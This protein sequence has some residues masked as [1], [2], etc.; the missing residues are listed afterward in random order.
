MAANN[1]ILMYGAD[2]TVENNR[3]LFTI[4][5]DDV[6]HQCWYSY[7]PGDKSNVSD[8]EHNH[9]STADFD[10][11]SAWVLA[12]TPDL[13]HLRL[14]RSGDPIGNFMWVAWKVTGAPTVLNIR[15]LELNPDGTFLGWACPAITGF[16]DVTAEYVTAMAAHPT[17]HQVVYVATKAPEAFGGDGNIRVYR[18]DDFATVTKVA[19]L[20]PGSFQLV[21]RIYVEQTT[22]YVWF[23]VG[24]VQ[25]QQ[26]G[27]SGVPTADATVDGVW[28]ASDG[29]TFTL[30]GGVAGSIF[31]D[32][33]VK[34]AAPRKMWAWLSAVNPGA[35]SQGVAYSTDDGATW[36]KVTVYGPGGLVADKAV[37]QAFPPL[38]GALDMRVAYQEE[39]VSGNNV[40]LIS[41]GDGG[42]TWD[43]HGQNPDFAA[44]A[45]DGGSM[46]TDPLIV[47]RLATGQNALAGESTRTTTG[48]AAGFASFDPFLA[49]VTNGEG[50][51]QHTLHWTM[52]WIA[53]ATNAT[54]SELMI[55]VDSG[56]TWANLRA[57][58]GF[59]ST[60][61]F[62]GVAFVQNLSKL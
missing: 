53:A 47:N 36:T 59:T 41:S 12:Q 45:T 43:S 23:A 10:G 35:T 34:E 54:T 15:N 55:S 24:G 58:A 42:L 57:A 32:L 28:G 37:V 44:N 30:R 50:H 26:S 39:P 14:V 29:I 40:I 25:M 5:P 8:H 16:D 49:G 33:W 48:E 9:E 22:G 20:N 38:T 60:V 27:G 17:N 4:P 61:R 7:V 52:P 21:S 1:V 56:E 13:G 62:H 3:I 51:R 19:D 2:F 11:G 46:F 6:K 18:S 31:G